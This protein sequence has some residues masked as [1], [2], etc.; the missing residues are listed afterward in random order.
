MVEKN[1]VDDTAKSRDLLRLIVDEVDEAREVYEVSEQLAGALPIRSFDD[2]AKAVGAEGSITFRGN[3]LDIRQ[4]AALVPATLFP[5]EDP[6]TLVALVY[7][8]VK[9]APRTIQYAES[10]PHSAQRRLRRLGLFG[11]PSGLLGPVPGP[12]VIGLTGHPEVRGQ[13][14]GNEE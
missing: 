1:R 8:A 5:I 4:F 11:M 14:R 2:I 10:D 9:M 6:Q 12:S 13:K 3:V 7:Q